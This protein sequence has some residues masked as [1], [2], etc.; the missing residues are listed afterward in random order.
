MIDDDDREPTQGRSV[1]CE[2]DSAQI[3]K[4]CRSV[5]KGSCCSR[6][7]ARRL[8][9]S[10]LDPA[11]FPLRRISR[12]RSALDLNDDSVLSMYEENVAELADARTNLANRWTKDEVRKTPACNR[13]AGRSLGSTS[14]IDAADEGSRARDRPDEWPF[15][16]VH[17]QFE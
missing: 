13:G 3:P 7:L 14:L 15:W 6:G 16:R 8:V 5:S 4:C 2:Q 11:R 10:L 12:S 1:D 17:H 9:D